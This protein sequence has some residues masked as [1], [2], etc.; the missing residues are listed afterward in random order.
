MSSPDI[1]MGVNWKLK[2]VK[3]IYDLE[4]KNIENCYIHQSPFTG[5]FIAFIY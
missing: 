4:N 2:Y 1:L 3:P 5:Q